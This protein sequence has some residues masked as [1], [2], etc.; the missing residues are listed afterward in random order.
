M[1]LINGMCISANAT[2]LEDARLAVIS[3]NDFLSFVCQCPVKIMALLHF[4]SLTCALSVA[5]QPDIELKQ[6]D[7]EPIF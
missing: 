1:A 2:I 3:R 6:M 5:K 4:Q 7:G